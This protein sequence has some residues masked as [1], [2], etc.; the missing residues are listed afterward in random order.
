MTFTGITAFDIHRRKGECADPA[1]C[2]LEAKARKYGTVWG[3][4]D[5]AQR[6][7]VSTL[8]GANVKAAS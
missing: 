6:K 5:T 3:Q 1:K 7:Y 4:P 2:G 8:G